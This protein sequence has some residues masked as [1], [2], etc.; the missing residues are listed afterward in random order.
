MNHNTPDIKLELREHE[1][2]LKQKYFSFTV[3]TYTLKTDTL[4]GNT[5]RAFIQ[6]KCYKKYQ[7]TSIFRHWLHHHYFGNQSIIELLNEGRDYEM[8]HT[9]AVKRIQ[10]FWIKIEPDVKNMYYYYFTKM[11]DLLFKSIPRWEELSQNRRLWFFERVHVPIDKY[12]LIILDNY[13]PE[14]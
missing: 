13:H 1:V 11:I 9:D 14:Y 2:S 8:I 7:P 6:G 5:A 4:R 12:S 10:K 3:D